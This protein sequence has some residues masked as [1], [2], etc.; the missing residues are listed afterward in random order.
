MVTGVLANRD[1][2]SPDGNPCNLI[3][4]WELRLHR[5]PDSSAGG[6]GA[7]KSAVYFTQNDIDGP[8]DG[9]NIGYQRPFAIV[10][11]RLQGSGTKA[12]AHGCDRAVVVPSLTMK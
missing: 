12:D 10:F 4:I 8:N 2:K 6:S 11:R 9:H 1:A 5:C 3:G 7:E